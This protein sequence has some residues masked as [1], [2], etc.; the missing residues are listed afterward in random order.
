M[1]RLLGSRCVTS[2]PSISTTP[3]SV[4]SK[5]AITLSNVDFPQPDGPSRTVK[6]PASIGRWMSFSTCRGPK[7]LESAET[8]TADMS[9]FYRAG[10]DPTHEVATGEEIDNQRR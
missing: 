10:S 8:E 2:V 5:P 3:A 7:D 6:S 1:P 9:A 4:S